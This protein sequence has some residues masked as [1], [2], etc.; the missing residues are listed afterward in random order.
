MLVVLSAVQLMSGLCVPVMEDVT[1][2]LS[3]IGGGWFVHQRERL[4]DLNATMWIE[5]QW[6]PQLQRQNDQSLMKAFSLDGKATH[7]QKLIANLC[8]VYLR[9]ITIAELANEK[10]TMIPGNR[11]NGKWRAQSSLE[12][13]DIPCPQ[14][15]HWRIFRMLVR[16]SFSH[17]RRAN[18]NLNAP[19]ILDN[20]LGK[21]NIA[22]RHIQYDHYRTSDQ[23]FMRNGPVFQVYGGP[24][25]S[26]IF[27]REGETASI[28]KHSIPIS[29]RYDGDEM[30][31]N[32]KY[33]INVTPTV[34]QISTNHITSTP[35][36]RSN[37]GGSDGSADIVSGSRAHAAVI[38]YDGIRHLSQK[39]FAPSDY[40][41]SYRAELEGIKGVIDIADARQVPSVNHTCDNK[42]AVENVN[43]P[44]TTQSQTL[45][46]EADIIMAIHKQREQSNTKFTLTWIKA[47]QDDKK[48]YEELDE[49]AQLNVDVDKAA[50]EERM[51]GQVVTPQPYEGCGA[52]LIINGKWVTTKYREQIHL[53]ST[54]PAHIKFFLEKYKKHGKTIDDYNSI[55]WRGIGNARSK[56][57]PTENVRIMKLMNG[58]LNTGRQKK[59]FHGHSAEC[60]SCGIAEETQIHMYQCSN[61]PRRETRDEA[62]KLLEKYYHHHDIPAL[63]YVPFVRLCWLAC[64]DAELKLTGTVLPEITKA[65]E[66]QSRLGGEFLLRGYLTRDWLDA[67]II[68][69]SKHPEQK[70]NHLY[71]GLWITLFKTIWEKRNDDLHGKNNVVEAY[72]R[73]QLM[74]ELI[75]WKE[76]SHSRLGADQQYLTNY[77]SEDIT[78]WRTTTM[79]ENV[80]LLV[81]A[82][83]NHNAEL[84][85]TNQRR[86]HEYFTPMNLDDISQ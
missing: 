66:N 85:G 71:R 56:L 39:R 74:N 10:G 43:N 69:S 2:D 62:F 31:T 12:W 58:W 41:S 5:H 14:K 67:L 53:A 20:S 36:P 70:L 80:K 18:S 1:T 35:H 44:Y 27:F 29:A 16:R 49:E 78:K 3:Y 45:A 84:L 32:E 76:Q 15:H 51:N 63:V 34:A 72:E 50:G 47:H 68:H 23:A 24:T 13:P 48:K 42:S 54:T 25:S 7:Q 17:T 57:N 55:Y 64:E 83:Q 52:M 38:H 19:V 59:H 11:M 86:I 8:R 60:P 77:S 21:W 81:K 79:R 75:E 46:P 26:D 40:V 37:M 9:V 28:P 6:T 33:D 82:A 22:T 65:V 73:Q 61:V 4:K 30:W